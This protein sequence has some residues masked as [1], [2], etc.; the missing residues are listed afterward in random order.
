MKNERV[1]TDS[2]IYTVHVDGV[3]PRKPYAVFLHGGPGFNSHGERSLLGGRLA[4][5]AN[6]L[7]FDL[8][9]SGEFEAAAGC[10][11]SWDRQLSDVASVIRHFTSEP[12]H[13]IT[14]CQGTL[15]ANDLVS[16][17][18]A[19]ARSLLAL[20]PI[21][22]LPEVFRHI[23]RRSMNEGRLPA[24]SLQAETAAGIER[25]LGSSDDELKA[26]DAL[27]FLQVAGMIRDFQELYWIDRSAMARYLAW[28]TERPFVPGTFVKLASYLFERGPQA[29][30]AFDG[31]PVRFLYSDNDWVAPW[32]RHGG[33][34]LKGVPHA[35]A[36]LLPGA[37][38]WMQFEKPE[39]CVREALAFL[40]EVG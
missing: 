17:D 28:M 11:L 12:V 39:E 34:L 4:A 27:F 7:W 5:Q 14:H 1:R 29:L 15:I 40:S 2:G 26:S 31:I 18:L 21:R 35:S 23:L 33:E 8:I 9:G 36:K 37:G 38:H 6:L 32:D 30:P 24:Q 20:S 19:P 10:E 13:L 16:R 25:F 3:D 22:S